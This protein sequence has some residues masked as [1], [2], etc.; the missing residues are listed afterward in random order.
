VNLVKSDM[1]LKSNIGLFDA[2]NKKNKFKKL[3]FFILN[4]TTKWL[5]TVYFAKNVTTKNVG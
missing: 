4:K 3:F 2:F 1:N 5:C